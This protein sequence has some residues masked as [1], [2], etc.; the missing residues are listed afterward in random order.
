MII[1]IICNHSSHSLFFSSSHNFLNGSL[2]EFPRNREAKWGR[3]SGRDDSHLVWVVDKAHLLLHD[4]NHCKFST[5]CLRRQQNE[6]MWLTHSFP[7]IVCPMSLS[8]CCSTDLPPPPTSPCMFRFTSYDYLFV[9]MEGHKEVG[10]CKCEQDNGGV[11]GVAAA[12]MVSWNMLHTLPRF[13]VYLPCCL[14]GRGRSHG[15][16]SAS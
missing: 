14:A 15:H 13:S 11:I 4:Q 5:N 10:G 16:R 3:I 8:L 7:T 1:V 2:V 12:F 6:L 9:G